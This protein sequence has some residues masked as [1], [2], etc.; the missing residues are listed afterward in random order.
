MCAPKLQIKDDPTSGR[1]LFAMRSI[2]KDEVVLEVPRSHIVFPLSSQDASGFNVALLTPRQRLIASFW[3]LYQNHDTLKWGT[4]L[5]SLPKEF[6]LPLI[7]QKCD[8]SENYLPSEVQEM[9]RQ[10]QATFRR[11]FKLIS[12]VL[13]PSFRS[14]KTGFKYAWCCVNTRSV[15]IPSP[16]KGGEHTV[17]LVPFFDMLNHSSDARTILEFD[18]DWFRVRAHRKYDAGEQVFI[19]Y[20]AH[21]N[22]ALW[23]EY[24]FTLSQTPFDSVLMDDVICDVLEKTGNLDRVK[25]HLEENGYWSDFTIGRD[26]PSWRL[27]VAMRFMCLRGSGNEEAWLDMVNGTKLIVNQENEELTQRCLVSMTKRALTSLESKLEQAKERCVNRTA[28]HILQQ[29]VGIL[30]DFITRQSGSDPVR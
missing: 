3:R 28:I 17:G 30:K 18:G 5:S 29:K 12:R 22:S 19:N 6:S 2:S 24:G 16:N 27:M 23:V 1:G 13:D 7:S 14:D 8:E 21:D 15:S 10:Q 25:Q 11:D 26:G 20:G 9:I 4:Y